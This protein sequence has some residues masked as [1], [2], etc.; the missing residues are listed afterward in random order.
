M[1]EKNDIKLTEG[2]NMSRRQVPSG[3][4]LNENYYRRC[5]PMSLIKELEKNRLS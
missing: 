1:I 2:L 3:V 5:L 4:R